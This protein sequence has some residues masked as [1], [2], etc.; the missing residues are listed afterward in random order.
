MRETGWIIKEM[1]EKVYIINDRFEKVNIVKYYAFS[2]LL[3][4]KNIDI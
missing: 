1:K 3:Q 2:W 4:Y